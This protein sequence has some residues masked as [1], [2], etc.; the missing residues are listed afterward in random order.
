MADRVAKLGKHLHDR[1]VNEFLALP[2]VDDI[3]PGP[4]DTEG[5][6]LYQ[7]FAIELNKTTGNPFDL[8]ATGKARDFLAA[9]ALEKGL[10]LGTCDGSPRRQPIVPPFI[11]TEEELDKALDIT[12][13]ILKE[14]Q[15]V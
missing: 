2:C 14:L 10:L 1:L 13:S 6:G 8:E 4:E 5:K 15:P 7:S 12:L 3:Q 11:I 9:K